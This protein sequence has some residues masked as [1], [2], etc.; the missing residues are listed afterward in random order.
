M[1]DPERILASSREA[2]VRQWILGGVS[3]EQWKKAE[4]LA[5]GYPGEVYY[6]VG[7]HPWWVTENFRRPEVVHDALE[8]WKAKLLDPSPGLI[9]AGEMGLDFGKG[10]LS[11]GQK[12]FPGSKS[13]SF[14]D[15]QLEVWRAQ[16]QWLISHRRPFPWVLH[17]VHAHD[18]ALKTLVQLRS[19][20]AESLVGIVHGFSGAPEVARAYRDL[21]L[22]LSIGGA[23]I[24]AAAGRGRRA[25]R[26]S[27][28]ELPEDAW[29][30]ESDCPDQPPEGELPPT[31]PS[32]IYRVAGALAWIKRHPSSG[33]LE[34]RSLDLGQLPEAGPSL[35]W[36]E[37]NRLGWISEVV[38]SATSRSRQIFGL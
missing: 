4:A 7:L 22:H 16:L 17:L 8:E 19:S 6:T 25:L 33:R 29:V 34:A 32:L 23:A 24:S 12:A 27:L 30:F 15:F 18:L 1:E 28:R 38:N 5:Q 36:V 2:G 26:Q 21:G 9:G 37:A 10:C 13:S 31:H 20:R 3:P 14:C 35:D 11:R